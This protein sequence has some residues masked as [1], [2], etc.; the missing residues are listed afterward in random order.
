VGKPEGKRPQRKSRRRWANIITMDL[1]DV[2]CVM[3]WIH[4]AQ[5][6]DNRGLVNTI[7]ILPVP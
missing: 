5:D 2:G 4:L 1:R 6:R 7:I 3:D